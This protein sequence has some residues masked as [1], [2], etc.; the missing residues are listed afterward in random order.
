MSDAGRT[1]LLLLDRPEAAPAQR[2]AAMLLARLLGG[3][4]LQALAVRVPAVASIMPTEEVLT[5]ER[6]AAWDTAEQARLAALREVCATP[7]GIA[8]RVEEGD[9]ATLVAAQ[10]RHGAYLVIARPAQNDTASS[11]AICHA[12]LFA[13]GR[14]VLVVPA[15]FSG[16]FGQ[17]IAIAFKTDGR[18]EKAV[19]AALPL[20]REAKR[21]RVFGEA[22]LPATL[23]EHAIAA[24]PCAMPPGD[25]GV[26]VLTAMARDGDD[27]LVMG[28]YTHS[29]WREAL[30]GGV[31]RH[32]LNSA[33]VPVLM[34]H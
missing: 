25:F 8:L 3:L 33:L 5:T 24:T 10:G 6:Q 18:A 1:V 20:L 17:N 11:H 22:A 21:V 30:L 27:L 29:A 34:Q 12:A 16:S 28:A 14:P 26:A 9:P 15:T 32:V 13:T 31:T 2:A 4:R 19:L 7:P 23:M